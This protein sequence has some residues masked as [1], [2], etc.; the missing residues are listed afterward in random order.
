MCKFNIEYLIDMTNM[1]PDDLNRQTLGKIPCQC[2]RQHSRLHLSIGFADT[3]FKS[4][5]NAFSEMNKFIQQARKSPHEKRV[6]VFGKETMAPQVICASAQYLMLEYEMNLEAALQAVTQK[7]YSLIKSKLD[8]CYLDYLK[9]FEQYLKHMSVSL[10]GNFS[11]KSNEVFEDESSLGSDFGFSVN[12]NKRSSLTR[13][14]DSD[15]FDTNERFLEVD[16]DDVE[17]DIKYKNDL[18]I[19]ANRFS[20]LLQTGKN[21]R[22]ENRIRNNANS[23]NT[24]INSNS[25]FKMAWM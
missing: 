14:K 16:S 9:E 6:L 10:Y 15:V 4:L 3:S 8:K 19:T 24:E 20:N 18:K 12:A 25:N 7:S 23:S 13:E 21:E 5:F 1:R 17:E 2:K 11:Y 22:C